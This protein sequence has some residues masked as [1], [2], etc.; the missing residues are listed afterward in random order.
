[1]RSL[2]PIMLLAALL[3]GC[4]RKDTVAIDGSV[5]EV[6]IR[7]YRL[8]PQNVSVGRGRITFAITNDGREP[9]NFRVRRRKRE[10]VSIATLEPGEYGTATADLRPGEYVMFSSVGRHEALGEH[11]KLIVTRR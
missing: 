10:L 7:D 9:T 5:V 6:S 4:D 8:T 3:A 1:M 2:A 11:G